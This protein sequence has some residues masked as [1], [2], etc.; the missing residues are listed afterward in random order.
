MAGPARPAVVNFKPHLD[1]EEAAQD[2]EPSRSSA[3]GGVPDRS[4][5]MLFGVVREFSAERTHN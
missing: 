4:R 2:Q 5:E 1:E 3:S